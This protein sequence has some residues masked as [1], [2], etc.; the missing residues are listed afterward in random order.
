MVCSRAEGARYSL[1]DGPFELVAKAPNHDPLPLQFVYKLK[2]KDSDFDNCIYKAR[3]VMRGNLQYERKYGDTYAP[4]A[5]LWVVRTLAAIAAQ[6]GLVMKKFDLT[7]AFLVVEM[8]RKLYVSIPGYNVPAGKAIRLSKALYG[9]KSSGALYAKEIRGFLEGLGFKP[10]SV[11]ET[12]FRLT[13]VKNR[14]VC[15]LLVS[16]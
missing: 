5:R 11:N 12:L 8:D 9:G 13:K 10:T 3:L 2:V 15:T 6:E 4:T 14:K 1:E 7:G 16:L